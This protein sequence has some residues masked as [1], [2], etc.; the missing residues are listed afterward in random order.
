MHTAQA[1][2]AKQKN[3]RRAVFAS[4]LGTIIEWYDYGLYAAA[5]GLI[6]N[7]L[8]FPQL[9][10]LA[11]TL[12]AFATFAVGFIV[13]PV[14]GIIISHIGDKYGRKP[15]LIFCITIMGVATVGLGILPTYAQVGILAPI[16]LILMRMMQGFG[17]GAELAGAITLI[18]EYTP[19]HRRAFFTSIPNAAT[20]FGV[21]IA[22]TTFLMISWVPEDILFSWVWRV[23]FILSLALFGV[24]LYIRAKLDETPEYVA[25]MESAAAKAK[26]AKVPVAELFKNSRREVLCGFLAMGGHQALSYVLNTFAISYMTYTLGMEKTDSLIVLIVALGVSLFCAPIGGLLA[27]KFGSG[28]I[29]AAGAIG[30]LVMV[31]P[32]FLAIDSKNV[33]LAACVMSAVYGISWG[34]TCGAQGAFLAN[35]FPTR[36]R[37]SGIAMCRELSGA[38]IGGPTPFIATALVAY[39]GGKPTY[40]MLYLGLF[41]LLTLIA[42]VMGKH[43]SRHRDDPVDAPAP[44]PAVSARP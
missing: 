32:L 29:F 7:K 9:S 23:P 6:I 5:S 27:D 11:G 30:A 14:G 13:R 4:T 38:F 2:Q 42:V 35:L 28:N 24:A 21:M 17:A 3:I 1:H 15:A 43:L 33:V 44:H 25:A 12:A 22:I 19:P 20:N 18:A 37:F 36:Y 39:A 8:F 16:L 10:A 26:D 31:W 41:S 34:C 40:L